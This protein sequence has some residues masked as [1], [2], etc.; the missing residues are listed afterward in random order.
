MEALGGL[1]CLGTPVA[2]GIAI[3][4]TLAW[5]LGP[6]NR[7]AEN[8]QY[9]IQYGLA[10][11]LSLFVLV[12]FP[13]GIVRWTTCHGDWV[14]S[15]EVAIDIL[16]GIVAVLLW[17]NTAR[18]LSR[19]GVHTVWRRCVVLI[20]V[21]PS[22]IVGPFAVFAPLISVMDRGNVLWLLADVPV[23]AILYLL[24]RFTRA[25]VA[26]TAVTSQGNEG[27]CQNHPASVPLTSSSRRV[28]CNVAM[29]V[30]LLG[31]LALAGCI[32]LVALPVVAPL[33]CLAWVLGPL[34]RAAKNR[35]FPIQFG[36]ADLLCLFVLIQLP[37]GILHWTLADDLK[38]GIVGF[39]ILVG[40]AAGSVWWVCWHTMSRAGI[41]VVWQ[42]CLV[43]ALVLPGGY[44]GSIALA[45]LP[46][47]AVALFMSD[48]PTI[49]WSLLLVEIILPAVLYYFGRFTRAI[50]AASKDNDVAIEVI[51]FPEDDEAPTVLE[52]Q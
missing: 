47:V 33:L 29:I 13:I 39:D 16:I 12:Q 21:V 11:L 36:L 4:A 28:I 6:L 25:T 42:R 45:V 26:S 49:A 43:L 52:E 7:A 50:V 2:L 41:Q 44:V 19:A 9:P 22:L 38:Q 3:W 37:V 24:G 10:D 32:A 31:L 30:T 48:R 46:F 15:G 5:I 8:R 27:V 35:Q 23:V 40:I 1:V 14:Q 17:W 34:D 51:L 20:L 18:L